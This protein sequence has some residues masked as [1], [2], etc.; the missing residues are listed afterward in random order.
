MNTMSIKEHF[1]DLENIIYITAQLSS[2]A[3]TIAVAIT[4]SDTKKD[5][6]YDALNLFSDMLG[7]NVIDLYDTYYHIEKELM[8]TDNNPI[9][10]E[11]A[12]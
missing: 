9:T 11:Q 12:S 3:K 4:E 1:K 2:M 8:F 10:L 6:F 7:N 5:E